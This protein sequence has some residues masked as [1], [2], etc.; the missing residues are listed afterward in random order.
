[1]HMAPLLSA[2][3]V[4]FLKRCVGGHEGDWAC[5]GVMA[6][7]PQ[8]KWWQAVAVQGVGWGAVWDRG[9]RGAWG[10]SVRRIM[11]VVEWK[12]HWGGV[13]EGE[14]E[15]EEC[16][17]SVRSMSRGIRSMS[18]SYEEQ[19]AGAWGA[20]AGV[21]GVWGGAPVVWGAWGRS[22]KEHEEL[23]GMWAGLTFLMLSPSLQ[24]NPTER[25]VEEEWKGVR[26][27]AR[28][29]RRSAR[30]VGGVQGVWGGVQGIVRGVQGVWRRSARNV[31]RTHIPRTPHLHSTTAE[32][33]TERMG[34]MP[35][36]S[37]TCWEQLYSTVL[38]LVSQ[39]AQCL[40]G[41]YGRPLQYVILTACNANHAL[42]I[43]HR[44]G[45]KI[46]SKKKKKKKIAQNFVASP[47]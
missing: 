4:H 19:W 45:H 40:I 12:E 14:Q 2:T 46:I 25:S 10:A 26:R 22:V 5:K 30:S 32:R 44:W 24:Y 41:Q 17:Q 11:R 35:A 31:S 15:C 20:W 38:E 36:E 6:A 16:E 33:T 9:P 18:R 3:W 34:E 39:W 21:W 47:L 43:S 7:S 29:V 27:S 1:M 42:L 13:Q 28:S 37:P 8:Y 23:Q